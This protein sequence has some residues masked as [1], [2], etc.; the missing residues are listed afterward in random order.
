ML[1]SGPG[2]ADL[3]ITGLSHLFWNSLADSVDQNLHSKIT[4]V[5]ALFFD[6]VSFF[7]Q[8]GVPIFSSSD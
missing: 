4:M 3:L 6:R 1:V 5:R 2:S 7:M 8:S